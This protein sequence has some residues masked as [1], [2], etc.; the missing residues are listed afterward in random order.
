MTIEA[1][2][3]N[4]DAYLN[5]HYQFRRVMAQGPENYVFAWSTRDIEYAHITGKTAVIWN[6]QTSTI[7]DGDFKK[8]AL[9]PMI[10][11]PPNRP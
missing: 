3:Y 1:G 6:S 4:F 9:L 2:S 11:L 5:E 8:I 10:C 7:I